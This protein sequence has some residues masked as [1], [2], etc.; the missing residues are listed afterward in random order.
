MKFYVKQVFALR[1]IIEKQCMNLTFTKR[2]AKNIFSISSYNSLILFIFAIFGFTR[3]VMGN[4][5]LMFLANSLLYFKVAW[6]F[7][8]NFIVFSQTPIPGG[9]VSGVWTKDKTPCQIL[10]DVTIAGDSV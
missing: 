7:C 6:L 5:Q 9:N 8:I 1:K 4:N 10:G 2:D 3:L